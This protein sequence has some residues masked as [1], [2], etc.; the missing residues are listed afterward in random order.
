MEIGRE[1]KR[2]KGK[3]RGEEAGKRFFFTSFLFFVFVC[4]KIEEEKADKI[5]INAGE[6]Q[7]DKTK[8]NAGE[9]QDDKT[10]ID[11]IVSGDRG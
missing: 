11:P 3:G 5:K 1:R 4:S 2:G 10:K 7:A 6:I 9:I 8:I